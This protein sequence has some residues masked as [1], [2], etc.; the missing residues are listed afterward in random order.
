MAGDAAERGTIEAAAEEG[1]SARFDHVFGM[2]RP[3]DAPM[4]QG[5]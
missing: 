1:L 3:W 5:A 2:T 4:R